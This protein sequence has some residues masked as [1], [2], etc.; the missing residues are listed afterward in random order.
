M[1]KEQINQFFS[2]RPN[3]TTIKMNG[4]K[5]AL[6]NFSKEEKKKIK[7]RIAEKDEVMNKGRMGILP[8]LKINGIQVTKDNIKDFEVKSKKAKVDK[9][10]E[11]V[12]KYPKKELND[13]SFKEL[14]VIGNKLGTTDRSKK[15]LIKEILKLQ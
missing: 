3:T 15:D 10:K 4:K 6:A 12:K 11:V 14:K 9:V 13:M 7:D 5:L 8:G 2:N 1:I